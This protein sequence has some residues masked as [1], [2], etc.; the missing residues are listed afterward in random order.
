MIACDC[1]HRS[2]MHMMEDAFAFEIVDHETLTPVAEGTR[3]TVLLTSLF[4]HV[5]PVIRFNTHDVSAV[6]PGQCACGG[7]HRRL[8]RIFGRSDS[9]IKLRGVNVFSEAIGEVISGDRR[10]NGEYVCIV[11]R[12]DDS[13]RDE[14][15][16][17]VERADAET[18]S[19][20]IA[21]DL[22]VRLKEA[23]GVKLTL[24]I[25]NPGELDRWTGLTQTSKVKRVIDRRAPS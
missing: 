1:E 7:T 22:A 24:K 20:G 9:M 10:C 18:D 25:V 15:T 23:V 12:V 2:G 6:V 17:M 3:G 16:V 13:G 21:A 5:A 4:K 14:M 19:P 8:E 11:E